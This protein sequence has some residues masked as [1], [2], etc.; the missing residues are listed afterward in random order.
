MRIAIMMRAMDQDSGFRTIT[1]RLVEAMLRVGREH[2]YV[3]LYRTEKWVGRFASFSN[4]KEVL[5]WAPHK[6]FWDQ[7]AVPYRAWREGAQVIFNP[8]FTVPLLSHCPV[9]MGL[10]EPA[11][12]AWPEHYEKWDVRYMKLM[13]PLYCR[14]AAHIFPNSRFDL[15]E[16]KK[17]L[18]LPFG[19]TTIVY[20]APN[21][22]FR[23]IDSVAD[24]ERF[25]ETYRLPDKFILS[26][27]RVD[28]TGMDRP[29]FYG[30]KNV[31]ATLRAFALCRGSVPHKLVIAGRNVREYL[32][33][34]GWAEAGLE[35]VHFT[36]FIP[37]EE[38]PK[39]YNLA[40]LF[41]MPSFYEGFG[42]AA[43]EAMACGCPVVASRTGACPE[44]TGGAALLAD[45]YDP[46]DFADKILSV[47]TNESLRRELRSKSL[48]RAAYFSWEESGRL[49]LDGL[50]RAVALKNAHNG[51]KKL[52]IVRS[53]T[54]Y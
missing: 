8:K 26:V 23:P 3:L 31:E 50:A 19:N 24:L 18:G 41:V 51:S 33:H 54:D 25:R 20:S 36:G 21:A 9:T 27:T 35:G 53:K 28:H 4:A 29:T 10:Q 2:S 34:T 30:G 11:W 48:A 43:V 6:L 1:E 40:G 22:Y 47:L 16:T 39:L 5:L 32:L 42:L 38:L 12:W 15:E 52:Q 37:H 44:V 49:V 46:A 17:Y 14:R 13:L 7:V 45:P